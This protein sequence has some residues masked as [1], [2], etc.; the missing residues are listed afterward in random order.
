VSLTR[1]TAGVLALHV[2]LALSASWTLAASPPESLPVASP[3]P[4][5]AERLF[6]WTFESR[7]AYADGFNDVDVDVL[8]QGNGQTWRVPAFWRGG[9]IWTVRFAPPQPGEYRYRL[10]STDRG[11]RDL[12]GRAGRVRIDAYV[13][14]NTLLKRGP[15]RVSANKRY[16]EHAD[17]TPF[18]WLGDTWWMGLSDRV[19]WNGFQELA[20]DRR[21]KGF[22]VVQVCAGLAPSNEE[23]AP[24][25]PGFVNEGGA[26]WDAEFQRINPRF[27][28]YA[29]RRVAHL[30][31]AQLM[32][33]L[34]GAWR[35]ALGQM[36][37]AKLKKHWRY[38]I[39]RYGAYPVLWIVGG[40]VYDPPLALLRKDATAQA[41]HSPGWSEV[42]RY[43]RQTDPYHHPVSVHEV[44]PPYD[45]ALQD[46]TLTDFDFLQPSHFGWNSIGTEVALLGTHYARTRLTKPII[47][48]E[49]GYENLGATHLQDFQRTAFWLAM[50]NGAAGHSYGSGPTFE[51]NSTDKPLQRGP[52]YTFMTWKEGMNYP[53]SYEIGIGGK[54]LQRYPWWRF[55]PRP[56]WVTP[57]GTTLLQPQDR[58]SDFDIDLLG[59]L[60]QMTAGPRSGAEDGPK[61]IWRENGGNF[62]SPYAAGIAGEVRVIYIPAF[63][64]FSPVPPTIHALETGVRYHAYY[65]DPMT[66]TTF[67]LGAIEKPAPAERLPA[68]LVA[69]S[70]EI[71]LAEGVRERDLVASVNIQPREETSLVLRYVDENEYL[72]ATYSP[73]DKTIHLVQRRN[74]KDGAKL[75]TTPVPSLADG[76]RLSAEVRGLW[77][78]VSIADKERTFTSAI[79]TIA[80]PAAAQAGRV[81]IRGRDVQDDA[82]FEVRQSP[83]RVA[84][85]QLERRLTDAAGGFR[86]EMRGPDYTEGS[87][88]VHKG[89][90]NF[91]KD[92][93]L[94]LDAYQP[95]RLP[96]PQDWILVL[97]KIR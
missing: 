49:I 48:A 38:V 87:F 23:L 43:V 3:A 16:L 69:T 13:G 88:V 14:S 8:F 11:N 62:R 68:S 10:E 67:D 89:W 28:D 42:A 29:D 54:L 93:A 77:A 9:S 60:P 4:Q 39:A 53:G 85:V 86:G 30:L 12:N 45:T 90:D 71:A 80:T 21:S 75:A 91:G 57:R 32:P 18:Y 66:G 44:P 56:D 36:G 19:D 79:V 5:A 46:E 92:K 7:K 33:V 1:R 83:Q 59:M 24:V 76:A 72:R 51:G 41:L 78:I 55:Q 6:E 74:G 82:G 96:S 40:E 94:L 15:L 2:L 52:R 58:V 47:V 50:L 27:F 70:R 22:T 25:D 26:V 20:A 64:L 81:G 61:G 31:D 17:G 35:Q 73:A 65:W 34:V 95:D 97:E 63:S 84:D 37:V